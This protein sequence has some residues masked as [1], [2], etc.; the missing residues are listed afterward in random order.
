MA[1]STIKSPNSDQIWE[2]WKQKNKNNRKFK[3]YYEPKGAP[4]DFDHI[5]AAEYVQAIDKG[6]LVYYQKTKEISATKEK[7]KLVK[8]TADKIEKVKFYEF[9]GKQVDKES[10]DDDKMVA[11]YSTLKQLNCSVCKGKGGQICEDCKGTGQKNCDNC[12]NGKVKCKKCM[13]TGEL[14]TEIEVEDY[15]GRTK[16]LKSKIKCVDCF[17]TGNLVC[18]KCGGS[19]KLYCKNCGGSGRTRCKKCE[20]AG[21]MFDYEIRPVPFREVSQQTRELFSSYKISD[22][23]E[24]EIWKDLTD[25]AEEVGVI[26]V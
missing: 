24:K 12:S 9:N 6:V 22:R 18:K 20:G 4:Y 23:I 8:V 15:K 14:E 2:R 3:K 5:T 13:G 17:G 1:K 11:H 7:P 19:A 25:I 26:R 10:W 16:T 21:S